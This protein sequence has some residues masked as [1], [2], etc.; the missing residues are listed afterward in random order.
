M[1][2]S[3]W[4]KRVRHLNVVGRFYSSRQ[5]ITQNEVVE[6]VLGDLSLCKEAARDCAA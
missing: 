5:E 4:V 2:E 3:V 1:V 6:K